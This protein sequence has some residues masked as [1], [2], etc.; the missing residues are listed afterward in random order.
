MFQ[1]RWFVML[2][3]LAGIMVVGASRGFAQS[4]TGQL[5]GTVL[6]QNGARVPGASVTVTNRDTALER[7]VATND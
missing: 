7:Q 5:T 2:L 4:A 6:D 3:V 1:S